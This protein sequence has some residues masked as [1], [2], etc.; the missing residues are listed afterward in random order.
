MFIRAFL[1][2]SP[3]LTRCSVSWGHIV[4]PVTIWVSAT[5][6][7]MTSSPALVEV[8]ALSGAIQPHNSGPQFSP[9]IQPHNSGP[10]FRLTIQAHNFRPASSGTPGMCRPQATREDRRNP[11]QAVTTP[12]N[13]AE[14]LPLDLSDL[15]SVR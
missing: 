3:D 1:Q 8:S 2:T 11:L 6:T 9:T 15:A 12:A 13:G 5:I 10:Q 7:V 14:L 4:A